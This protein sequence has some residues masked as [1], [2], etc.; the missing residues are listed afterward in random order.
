MQRLGHTELHPA[1]ALCNAGAIQQMD[2][3]EG[4]PAAADSEGVAAGSMHSPTAAA[5]AAPAPELSASAMS[6]SSTTAA[7]H[8]AGEPQPAGRASAAPAASDSASAT[9]RRSSSSAPKL[10]GASHLAV[11]PG[12]STS[13]PAASAAAPAAGEAEGASQPAGRMGD[14]SGPESYALAPEDWLDLASVPPSGYAT[15][16]GSGLL[17]HE[18]EARSAAGT[19]TRMVGSCAAARLP[20]AGVAC[21]VQRM[22]Q[23]QW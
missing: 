8:S 13:G 1:P 11:R 21:H 20:F 2:V 23:G 14:S 19:P 5:A 15:R 17:G 22:R 3:P 10:Q 16:Q 9:D 18:A 4:P 6:G 12:G 7:I